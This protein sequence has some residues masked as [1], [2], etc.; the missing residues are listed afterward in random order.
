MEVLVNYSKSACHSFVHF[1][2]K[3]VRSRY[4]SG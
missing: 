3:L 4:N 1:I 2:S